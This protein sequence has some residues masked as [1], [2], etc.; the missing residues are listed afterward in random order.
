MNFIARTGRTH[1]YAHCLA[2]TG[3]YI[4]IQNSIFIF[5]PFS[6]TQVFNLENMN[7]HC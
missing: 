6:L 2:G 3:I 4:D 7:F 5:F 1:I